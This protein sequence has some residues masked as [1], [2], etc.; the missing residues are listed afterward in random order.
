MQRGYQ[1]EPPAKGD[2]LV[3]AR[4]AATFPTGPTGELRWHDFIIIAHKRSSGSTFGY[5]AYFAIDQQDEWLKGHELPHE[6]VCFRKP[7]LANARAPPG[8]IASAKAI[9]ARCKEAEGAAGQQ[10]QSASAMRS[11]ADFR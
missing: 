3:G 4:G 11:A 8:A 1:L 5:Q 10:L 7:N 9:L 2:Q 6:G